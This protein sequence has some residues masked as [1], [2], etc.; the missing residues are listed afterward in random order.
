MERPLWHLTPKRNWELD[1][2]FR[3]LYAY[4]TASDVQNPPGLYV[5]DSPRYWEQYFG[6]GPLWAVRIDYHGEL[7]R[8]HEQHPEYFL[9]D[10]DKIEVL[11][12]LPL[13]E[14]IKRDQEERRRGLQ[15]DQQQY[16]GFGTVEDWWFACR[17]VWND[18][19]NRQDFVCRARKG[20]E[21]LM[22]EWRDKH[23]GFKNPRQYDRW[24]ERE[25]E[26]FGRYP[27]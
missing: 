19:K 1:Q 21:E 24:R 3:P 17:E 26:R 10:F 8:M 7:P 2:E 15:W 11:E 16:H 23:K 4:F 27:D 13:A 6:R 22:D 12:I 18:R 25:R 20:L 5:T 14:A 9:E